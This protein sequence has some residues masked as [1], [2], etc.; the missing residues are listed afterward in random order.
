MNIDKKVE[1]FFER[2]QSKEVH[3]TSDG[4]LFRRKDQARAHAGT[5]SN[6]EVSTYTQASATPTQGVS[7]LDGNLEHVEKAAQAVE[8]IGVLEALILEEESNA[9][10]KGALDILNARIADLTDKD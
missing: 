9:N 4:F 10:R 2:D 8:D 3:A 5:L 7:V 1:A 6:K